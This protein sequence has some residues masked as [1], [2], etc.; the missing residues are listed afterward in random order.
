MSILA[1]TS[2][3]LIGTPATGNIEYNGQFFGT[4]SAGSR[5]QLQR[6]VRATAVASTSG[7]SIDFTGIPAWT[8]KITVM[9]SGVSLNSTGAFLIQ[10]GD[11]GGVETSGYDATLIIGS[12][13]SA[14]TVNASV[15]GFPFYS[16][17]AVFTLS[18]SMII[19]NIT[20]NTWVEQGVFNN[21]VTTPFV[22]STAG[23]KT[24]SA[25][26]DRVR[27]TTTTGTDTFDAGS[28]N[29]IYEG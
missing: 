13:G 22:T 18:G 26:L 14:N 19:T 23:T 16:G 5:A 28:V 15:A 3:T 9:F 21:S 25:T 27:I 12:N 7:T 20:G 29:I 2:D 1:L 10:L 11:S 17:S 24:L 4:D 6:I 8:E